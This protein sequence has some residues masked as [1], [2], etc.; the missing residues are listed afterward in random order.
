MVCHSL[1]QWTTF[2][3]TSPPWPTCLGW[4]HRL[5]LS[6]IELD[7]AVVLVWLDWLVFCDYGFIVFALWCPLA[8]LTVLLG[9]LLPWTWGI[10]SQLLQQSA[11]AAPYLG[12]RVA[13]LGCCPWFGRGVVPLC[14]A[15]TLPLQPPCICTAIA[16]VASNNSTTYCSSY[17][18][19][20][21]DRIVCM[22]TGKSK[23]I[24]KTNVLK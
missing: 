19:C 7:K 1:L 14:H 9:F 22:L 20:Y 10:S 15:S 23:K 3:Q 17:C 16:A 18:F 6:F 11:A 2:C 21:C 13:P 8:T 12:S 4:P 5:W 24:I